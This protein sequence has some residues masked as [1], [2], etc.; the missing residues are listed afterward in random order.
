[1]WDANTG[2]EMLQM[3]GNRTGHL[4]FGPDDRLLAATRRG[5]KVQ[6]LRVLPGREL[7]Q[8]RPPNEDDA[9]LS[10]R[11]CLQG[12]LLAVRAMRGLAILDLATGKELAVLPS[13]SAADMFPLGFDREGALQTYGDNGLQR[14]PLRPDDAKPG[15]VHVGPPQLLYDKSPREASGQT[16]DG[17]IVVYPNYS[18]GPIVLHLNPFQKRRFVGRQADVR[19]AAIS[20]EGR[21][22]ATGSH[23]ETGREGAKIWDVVSGEQVKTLPVS[24]LCQVGFSPDGRWL[25]TLSGV[26]HQC[27]LWSVGS[28]EAGPTLSAQQGFAFSEDGNWIAVDGDSPGVVRL[29]ETATGKELVR[30]TSPERTL[31]YSLLITPDGGQ[32]LALGRDTEALHVWDLRAI[33]RQLRDVGLDWDPPL[34]PAEERKVAPLRL[35]VE[36]AKPAPTADQP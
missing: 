2:R 23:S 11:P 9:Y 4:R 14:W 12:R 25:A 10:P 20:P 19:Y 30:L 17:Q 3:A 1:M 28:W 33:R 13:K 15:L 36:S 16:A 34:P 24:G 27:C 31:M 8:L 7:R 21:W 5:G 18:L 29:L 35:R 32:V 22:I 6:L 26:D